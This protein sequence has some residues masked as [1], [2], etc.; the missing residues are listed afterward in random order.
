MKQ[1]TIYCSDELNE[2]V[3]QVLRHHDLDGFIHVPELYGNRIRPKGSLE[4][5]VTWT[6]SAFVSFPEKEKLD[7][8]VKE[9]EAFANRCRVKPCLRIVVSPVDYVF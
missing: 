2:A 3:T 5:D 4:Q 8:V 7:A 1:L 6:A 9:L